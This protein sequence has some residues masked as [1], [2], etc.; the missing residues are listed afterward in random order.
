MDLD[1]ANCFD[2]WQSIGGYRFSMR[3]G[4][5][6]WTVQK[7][8]NII[9]SSCKAEYTAAF[10]AS[11]KAIWLC[12]L[13]SELNLSLSSTTIIFCNNNAA[14]VLSSNLSQ[15]SCSKHSDI[16]YHF[17]CECVQM[18]QIKTVYIN[19]KDNLTNIFTKALPPQQFLQLCILTGMQWPIFFTSFFY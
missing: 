14:I 1:C 16:K 19:T 3:S 15:H 7:Q 9:S 2:T 6:S 10:K 13:M 11:N 12:T 8:K 5:I 4:L 17:F 18:G